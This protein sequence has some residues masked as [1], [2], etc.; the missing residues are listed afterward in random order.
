[1]HLVGSSYKCYITMDGSKNVKFANALQQL[2]ANVFRSGPP[3]K[4]F[5]GGP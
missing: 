3:K 2:W 4:I 1:V 5:F